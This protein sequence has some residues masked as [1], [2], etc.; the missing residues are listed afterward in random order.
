VKT[1]VCGD[2]HGRW[3]YLN[4][5]INKKHP[6]IILQCGDFGFFPRLFPHKNKIK[7][8]KCKIYW[9]DGNHEDHWAIKDLKDNEVASN[10][11]YMK[12]GNTLILPDGKTVLFMGGADSIDKNTRIIGCDWFPDEVITQSDVNN[13]LNIKID[14]IISHTLPKEFDLIINN[15]WLM[16]KLRDPSRMALSYLLDKYRPSLWYFGHFHMHQ[17]GKYKNT[18]WTCLNMA[19]GGNGW[20]E[21]LKNKGRNGITK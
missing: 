12:R 2:I 9:C 7:N 10:V 15:K 18:E 11:F 20:W 14:I 4:D 3:S 16:E 17:T 6:D 13:L 1:M 8:G 5:I 19:G 21:W